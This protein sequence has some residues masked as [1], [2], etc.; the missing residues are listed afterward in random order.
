VIRRPVGFLGWA[1][2][3]N[4]FYW[5]G[6]RR[7][8]L[9]SPSQRRTLRHEVDYVSSCHAYQLCQ[10]AHC[11]RPRGRDVGPLDLVHYLVHFQDMKALNVHE[12]K[13]GFSRLLARVER[14]EEIIIARAGKP[15][16][17]LIAF[18]PVAGA[19]VLGADQGSFVVPADFD[20]PLPEDL[21]EAFEGR[22]K[23]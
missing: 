14:G 11:G 3:P 4:F 21:L 2:L 18:D 17:R 20:A 10:A 16:A 7:D 12:A 5:L 22:S 8:G 15:V 13:T 19:P 9:R 6:S 23:R 1:V